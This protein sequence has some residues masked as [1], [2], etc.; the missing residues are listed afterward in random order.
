MLGSLNAVKASV[1]CKNSKRTGRNDSELWR[2]FID[3]PFVLKIEQAWTCVAF[4]RK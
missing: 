2:T 3:I 1:F 4:L